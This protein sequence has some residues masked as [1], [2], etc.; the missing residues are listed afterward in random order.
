M[1]FRLIVESIA[2]RAKSRAAAVAAVALGAGA[3]SGLIL[4]LIGVGDRISEEMRRLDANIEILPKEKPLLA[5]NLPMLNSDI[6][7]WGN[8][9]RFAIPEFRLEKAGFEFVGREPDPRWRI[10]GKPGV[11][12]GVSLGLSPG[13]TIN[14]GRPL[15]VTGT[16]STGGD[17]DH[18][19]LVPLT[20]AQELAGRPGE[21]SRILVSATVT[22]ETDEFGRFNRKEKKFS[23]AQIER[24]MCTPFPTNVARECGNALDADAR[25]LRQISDNEGALLRRI[26]GVIGIL[27][28][29]AIL[30]ACLSVLA[31]MTASVVDR[32]KEIGLLK[33]LGAT[34]GTVSA[35]FIGEALLLA[36]PGSLIGYVIGLTAAKSMSIALFGSAVPGSAVVYLVTLATALFITALGVAWPL[37]RAVGLQPHRVLHEV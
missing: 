28:A 26:D 4:L 21:L 16:V 8:Q 17:E 5:Q 37:R 30:A 23:A 14:A 13:A 10:E 2:R 36:L 27:A 3:A 1:Y 25:V 22:A 9:V 12:A 7:R 11:L 24:M 29:A 35:L 33:A 19:V 32:Q 34:N 6:N 31:T 15:V 20:L 18:Q